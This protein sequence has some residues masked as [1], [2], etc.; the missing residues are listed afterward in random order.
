MVKKT[1]YVFLSCKHSEG[2]NHSIKT[3]GKSLESVT[4]LKY[5]ATTLMSQNFIHEVIKRRL[6][7]ETAFYI[8]VQNFLPYSLLP[9]SMKIKIIQNYNFF[10]FICM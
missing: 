6:N 4:K 3:S 9:K 7:S 5:L 2:Q 10:C 1:K 8:L